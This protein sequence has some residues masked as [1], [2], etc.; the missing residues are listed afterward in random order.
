MREL[1]PTSQKPE[2]NAAVAVAG[3]LEAYV[4]FLLVSSAVMLKPTT[5]MPVVWIMVSPVD[6][7][8]FC[9]PFIFTIELNCITFS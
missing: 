8:A 3:R 4:T 9:V 5:N 7:A 6:Y 1:T 2:Q